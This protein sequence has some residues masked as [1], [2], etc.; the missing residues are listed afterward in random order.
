MTGTQSHEALA[1]FVAAVD[2]F[3]TLGGEAS[4]AD[5]RERLQQASRR[6]R[7]YEQGLC[8][9]MLD[10]LQQ[11]D[12]LRLLG[13]GDASRLAERVPTFSFT[14]AGIHPRDIARQLGELGIFAWNGNFYALSV[15]QAYGL[16]PQGMVRVGAVHYNTSEEVERLLTALQGIASRER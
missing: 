15:S 12:G 9:E 4:S 10:G 16:E 1:G 13:L 11:I 8:R 6:I 2:Y 5:R 14:L 7:E 3:A